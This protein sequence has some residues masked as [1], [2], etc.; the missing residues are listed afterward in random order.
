MIKTTVSIQT[1]LFGY[2]SIINANP[3]INQESKSPEI[4]WNIY[5]S[6]LVSM[7]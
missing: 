2:I 4:I 6:L 5:P 1:N 7:K 3:G